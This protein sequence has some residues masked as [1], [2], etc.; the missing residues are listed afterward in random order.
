ME[1]PP[2]GCGVR[3]FPILIVPPIK[4]LLW[5]TASVSFVTIQTYAHARIVAEYAAMLFDREVSSVLSVIDRTLSLYSELREVTQELEATRRNVE[6]LRTRLEVLKQTVDSEASILAKQ[7]VIASMAKQELDSVRQDLLELDS[8]LRDCFRGP[9]EG[10]GA[11]SQVQR[12]ERLMSL[13]DCW[14]TYEANFSILIRILHTTTSDQYTGNP[15]VMIEHLNII[16]DVQVK[17][18]EKPQA[19]SKPPERGPETKYEEV[20]R[21]LQSRL[22]DTMGT[23][24]EETRLRHALERFERGLIKAG[25]PKEQ[26]QAARRSA[27]T[28]IEEDSGRS[29]A[30]TGPSAQY[31]ILCVDKS[32]GSR[33]TTNITGLFS[34]TVNEN[35]HLLFKS[36]QSAGFDIKTSLQTAVGTLTSDALR[37]FVA[38]NDL[39]GWPNEKSRIIDRMLNVKNQAFDGLDLN[40]YDIILCFDR[41][42]IDRVRERQRAGTK[43]GRASAQVLLLA[44]CTGL[45]FQA[46]KVHVIIAAIKSAIMDFVSKHLEY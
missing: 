37:N 21:A 39:T 11:R 24:S 7:A 2:S 44:G 25:I 13:Q 22:P 8:I 9:R 14:K 29:T 41:S 10:L 16:L 28:V 23:E 18:G 6:K 33:S 43:T 34:Q 12:Q 26:A 3:T 20:L 17:P 36:V 4:L 45:P 27:E 1:P 35:G 30:L 40:C 31:Q 38:P 5:I 15:T 46:S 19:A 32:Q 42:G